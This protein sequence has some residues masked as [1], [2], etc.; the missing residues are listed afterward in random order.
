MK[1]ALVDRAA[2][3]VDS[4]AELSSARNILVSLPEG[5]HAEFMEMLGAACTD[6]TRRR[7]GITQPGRDLLVVDIVPLKPAADADV[8]ALVFLYD[9]NEFES[10]HERVS[11]L[12]RRNEAILRC[13]MDGFFVIDRDCRF[14]EVNEAFSRMVGYT[15]EELLGMRIT[16]LEVQDSGNDGVPAH[17]QTG[18]HQ[19]P[20]AHLHKHGHIVHLDISVNVLHDN[21]EKILV[22]F[23][24]DVTERK[25]AAD[26]LTRLTR[27]QRLIL[28]AVAEGIVGIDQSGAVTFVNPA[29]LDVLRLNNTS[30]IGRRADA[31]LFGDAPESTE[32]APQGVIDRVVT[33][34]QSTLQARGEML[35]SDG[36]HVQ[37][38]YS[39]TPIYQ[40]HAINGAV[41]VFKDMTE[42][43]RLER[44]RERLEVQIQSSKRLES[45][46]LLAGGI[47][48]DLNNM[49][50][51]IQGNASLALR[52]LPRDSG[53]QARVQRIVAACQRAS[54]VIDQVLTC[55]G[56]KTRETTVNDLNGIVREATEFM[57]AAVP[58]RVDLDYQLSTSPLLVEADAGQLHQVMTN[59]LVNA[60]EAIGERSGYVLVSTARV[61]LTGDE[62]GTTFAGQPMQP[63]DYARL[64]VEDTGC[65]MSEETVQRIFEPFFTE[66]GAG[67][68]LGLSAMHGVVRAHRGGVHVES[69]LGK[70]TRFTV[71]FPLQEAAAAKP[72]I[73]EVAPVVTSE[74]TILVIDDDLD[75]RDV[76]KDVL[77]GHGFNVITAEDGDRGL[78]VFRKHRQEIDLVLLDLIMPRKGGREVL[79]EIS[80]EDDRAKVI[81]ISGYIEDLSVESFGGLRPAAIV[82][83]PFVNDALV[84]TLRRVLAEPPPG[85]SASDSSQM[86][87]D[88]RV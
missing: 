63:G 33:S 16:D 21:G 40:G 73:S 52:E 36:E 76:L 82:R 58:A 25:R 2:N 57:R 67:R 79:L 60:V 1:W 7:L 6:G 62:L 69:Q 37:V 41:L 39:I 15:P 29:A 26:E 84:A 14:M 87:S 75:V 3:C 88:R 17:T 66:K 45:V 56:R 46:G 81:I 9:G 85:R 43:L 42:A 50:T 31:L 78:E 54:Q 68:G 74:A 5:C 55:A 61:T 72:E 38:E 34:G 30:V 48:H 64:S 35:R 51:G 10:S 44:E 27:Q 12:A 11:R 49:L 4:D 24:R 28:D 53:V 70:G 32:G 80:D 77:T 22:G 19:F 86:T 8:P 47:A 18:L 71:V 59:L 23:A 83:K 20:T 13:S 65:G